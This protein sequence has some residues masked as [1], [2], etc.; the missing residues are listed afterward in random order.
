MH[1]H[2]ILFKCG[3]LILWKLFK[4]SHA[5]NIYLHRPNRS[6]KKKK[7]SFVTYAFQHSIILFFTYPSL[8]KKLGSECMVSYVTVPVEQSWLRAMLLDPAVAAWQC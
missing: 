2:Y 3:S 6:K 8:L 5:T 7:P 4:L 1:A